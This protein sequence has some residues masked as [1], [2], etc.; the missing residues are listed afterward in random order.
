MTVQTPSDPLLAVGRHLAAARAAAADRRRLH[1]QMSQ[2]VADG[3]QPATTGQRAADA[4]ARVMG[5]WRFLIAQSVFLVGWLL[6]NVAAWV[7]HWDPYPFILLNLML[8]FQAAY[9]AP[10]LLMSAN[11]QAAVDRGQAHH[12]YLVNQRAEAEV[13][14]LLHLMRAQLAQGKE[15]LDR[16]ATSGATA[17]AAPPG[18]GGSPTSGEE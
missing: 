4:V 8:S 6:L 14:E 16:L 12:D 5:S 17:Q 18:P 2:Q 9:A 15:V 3:D 11:R 13:E 1:Q 7:A 10:I